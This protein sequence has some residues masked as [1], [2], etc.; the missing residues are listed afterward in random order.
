MSASTSLWLY[1]CEQTDIARSS[2]V[3]S[4]NLNDGTTFVL[5]GFMP[6]IS[7]PDAITGEYP[8]VWET[9]RVKVVGATMNARQEC[10]VTLEAWARKCELAGRMAGLATVVWL[11]YQE[12]GATGAVWVKLKALSVQPS[13]AGQLE[14]RVLREGLW[15]GT[16]ATAYVSNLWN[17]RAQSAITVWN[18]HDGLT[19]VFDYDNAGAASP[20]TA[21]SFSANKPTYI[22]GNAKGGAASVFDGLQDGVYFG[23][24]DASFAGFALD[25]ANGASYTADLTWEYSAGSVWTAFTPTDGTGGFKT[26]GSGLVLISGTSLANWSTTAVNSITAYWQRARISAST[27]S[28]CPCTLQNSGHVFGQHTNYLS[29]HNNWLMVDDADVAGDAP[30]LAQVMVQSLTSAAGTTRLARRSIGQGNTIW[31][32]TNQFASANGGTSSADATAWM[33]D[34]MALATAT[35]SYA[36]GAT[37]LALGIYNVGLWRALERVQAVTTASTAYWRA[38]ARLAT[39][40]AVLAQGNDVVCPAAG[41]WVIADLGIVPVYPPA[42]NTPANFIINTEY[43][44]SG[45]TSQ[46]LYEDAMVLM[47]LDEFYHV[48]VPASNNTSYKL[49]LSG[50]DNQAFVGSAAANG[51]IYEICEP[52]GVPL[53]LEPNRDNYLF[54]LCDRANLSNYSTDQYSVTVYVIPRFTAVRGAL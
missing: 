6:T 53:T 28:G 16:Y 29:A 17:T 18:H 13:E 21:G 9:L 44:M 51:S 45:A 14:V 36:D 48:V 40:G 8:D 31:A 37:S 3:S 15:W 46:V 22:L 35:T 30:A 10:L 27:S 50:I 52:M 2:S 47:P 38:E 19:H 11:K 25:I 34:R 4:R 24:T 39:T 54:L 20:W 23:C 32:V 41:S 42:G 43:K 26:A 1:E 5:I 49:V 7:V 12:A 33:G